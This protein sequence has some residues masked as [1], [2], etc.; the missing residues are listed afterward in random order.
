MEHWARECANKRIIVVSHGH[1]MRAL[2]IEIE[3][4]LPDDFIRMD[5]SNDPR[6]KIRNCQILWYSRKDPW[7]GEEH[8]H[9]VAVRSV[10]P[11]DP[12]GDYGWRKIPRRKWSNEELIAEVTKTPRIIG[13]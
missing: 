6:D 10:C 9:I 4:L 8:P 13:S 5:E 12:D 2:Q 1:V 7:T 11:W 3:S